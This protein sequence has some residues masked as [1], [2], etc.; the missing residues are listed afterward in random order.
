[1]APAS[2][3]RA[4]RELEPPSA[5]EGLAAVERVPF[6]RSASAVEGPAGVFVA[7][8]ALGSPGCATALMAADPGTPSLLFD[9]APGGSPE[10]LAAGADRLSACL[11]GPVSCAVCPHGGG[12]PRC[13]CR[14]PLPGLVLAFA[15][16]Q[17]VNIAR[18]VLIGA[19]PAH[20]TLAHAVGARY[21]EV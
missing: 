13:W 7:G 19:R 9:W 3:M 16:A 8:A 5:D 1:M 18:S 6:A 21:V 12:P 14:P 4:L 17:G 2:Q 20:R 15:F 11:S 10:D